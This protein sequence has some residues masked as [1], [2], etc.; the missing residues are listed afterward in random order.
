MGSRFRVQSSGFK[1][2]SS[3]F[4]GDGLSKDL[5]TAFFVIPAKAGIQYSQ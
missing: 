5:K 3:G 1:V 4:N 2:Q